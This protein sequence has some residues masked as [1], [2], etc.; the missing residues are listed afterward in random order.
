M[1]QVD[2][3][4]VEELLNDRAFD[5]RL[6]L[7][8]GKDGLSRR[9]VSARIQKPGLALAGYTTHIHPERLAVYFAFGAPNQK[10]EVF[11]QRNMSRQLKQLGLDEFTLS[12]ELTSRFESSNVRVA[13]VFDRNSH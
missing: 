2:S 5:L 13:S 12:P 3:I 1:G 4:R 6:E 8:A 7:V 9:I 10:S 11:A